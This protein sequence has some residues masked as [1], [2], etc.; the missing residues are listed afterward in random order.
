MSFTKTAMHDFSD[1]IKQ[2]S[3]M[4]GLSILIIIVIFFIPIINSFLVFI[5]KLIVLVL[6]SYAF[7]LNLKTTNK[8]MTNFSNLFVDPSKS[9]VRDIMVLSYIFSITIIILIGV[10]IKSF[11][12]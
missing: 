7:L 4:T 11:F 10:I 9:N 3:F 5:G 1:N 6:L 2:V 12:G 8:T